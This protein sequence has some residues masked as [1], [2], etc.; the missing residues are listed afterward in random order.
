MASTVE[1]STPD[2]GVELWLLWKQIGERVRASVVADVLE[3]SE[4]SEPE[5]TVLV[6]LRT[7][8]GTIRQNALAS[9]LGWD[10]TRLSHLLT[11]MEQRGYL[12]REKLRNGV[13][14]SVADAGLEVYATTE[15]LLA[16]AS[17]RHFLDRLDEGQRR[18]LRDVL[19]TLRS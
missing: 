12:S 5:M 16:A 14:I 8:G 15:P 2:D 10:R 17:R 13:E 3:H 11:R 6:Q 9:S 19:E 4:L 18:A 1:I 7:A